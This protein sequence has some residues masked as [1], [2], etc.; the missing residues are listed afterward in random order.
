MPFDENGN[1]TRLYGKTG[2]QDDRAANT[3]FWRPAM[4][5]TPTTLPTP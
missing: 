4:T 3:K 5:R 2:W 1:F